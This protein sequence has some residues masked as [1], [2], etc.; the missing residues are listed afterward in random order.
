VRC[1]TGY[2]SVSR[3]VLQDGIAHKHDELAA[4]PRQRDVEPPWVQDECLFGSYEIAVCE[5]SRDIR[6][7]PPN[8]EAGGANRET[9]CISPHDNPCARAVSPAAYGFHQPVLT[10]NKF[11]SG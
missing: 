8:R 9:V 11:D 5:T 2:I 4:G 7:T 10:W 6:A 1:V 3:Q